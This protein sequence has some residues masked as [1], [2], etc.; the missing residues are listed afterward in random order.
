[1][2]KN[3]IFLSKK[4]SIIE[5][6]NFYEYIAIMVDWW[7]NITSSLE[8]IQSRIKNPYFLEK[9]KEIKD[10]IESWDSFSKALKKLPDCF[11]ESETAILEA[12]ENSWTIQS[13]LE[14][15]SENL[16]NTNE[17]KGEIKWAL[18]YPIIILI[19]LL[20]SISVVMIMVIPGIIPL[21]EDTMDSLPKATLALMA[22]SDFF[23]N[24][25]MSM[26]I[27]LIAV[28]LWIST[29]K[30]T[31][32]GQKSFDNMLINMPL[33]WE[34]YR[35][36]ILANI[37]LNLWNLM[38]WGIQITKA[39]RLTWKATGSS[40]YEEAFE[41]I[42]SSV[43]SWKKLVESMIEAD[44]N[45]WRL[46]PA[47]YLQMIWVGEKTATIDKVCEKINAQYKKEVKSSLKNLTKWIEP[48]AIL[49]AWAFV[50]WFAFAVFGAVLKVTQTIG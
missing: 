31:P 14:S 40:V 39:L 26:I 15:L 5:K 42:N 32:N 47:D 27:A 7:V 20:L 30:Q 36:Y 3:N 37:A 29:Y 12:G 19:F 43:K 23:Q 41:E 21:F 16:R 22:T 25:Y 4:I 8:S 50:L 2:T 38:K 28:Y 33:I 24:N 18:T 35:N 6:A 44:E 46:F 10:F 1:M 34:L 48:M 13:S 17:L 11:E 9:I 45:T 49:L